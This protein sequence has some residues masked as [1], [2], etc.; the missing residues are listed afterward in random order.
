MPISHRLLVALAVIPT[1][2][3]LALFVY[4]VATIIWTGLTVEAGI[5]LG[6]F[7]DLLS[8]S[9]I[10]RAAW[11]TL[12]QAVVSTAVTLALGL[13]A[14]YLFG[15][16][17]FPGRRLMLSLI[18]IPFVLPTVVVASAFLALTKGW[19]DI[20]A[21]VPTVI[22][23][24]AFFNYAVVV[25]TVSAA[26]SRLDP[27]VEQA[28][29]VLGASPARVM[30]SVT[31]PR[32]RGSITAAAAIVFLFTFTSFGVVLIVGEGRLRTL[33]VETY[34][35]TVQL[36]NLPL[37]AALA[38]VQLAFITVTLLAYSRLRSSQS[39]LRAA[40]R[41][42]ISRDTFSFAA[43]NLLVIVLLLVLPLAA[44]VERSL[45]IGDR[46]GLD[47]YRSLTDA[48]PIGSP[49]EAIQ[50]S[51]GFSVIALAIAV[52]IGALAAAVVAYGRGL[53]AARLFDSLLMLPLG[54]SAV[55]IGF[56][57]LVALDQPIDLRTWWLL[58][59]LSHSLVALPLVVRTVAPVMA[60]IPNR[61]RE[62]AATLGASPARVWTRIDLPIVWRSWLVAAGFAFA[63]SL[64]E[65]G[66]TSFIARP[67]TTTMP[68]MI[69][70]FLSRPGEAN[71]GSAMAMSVILMVVTGTAILA[72]DRFRIAK[73]GEF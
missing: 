22:A 19:F 70:R 2:F 12:W 46:Y 66:A 51:L 29:A 27:S 23:A 67:A 10:R 43:C 7:V 6:A 24:H 17:E 69:F 4:P 30:R 60:G 58:V 8:R 52:T 45:R 65:F 18:T 47:H 50:N 37:A 56:G 40:R 64:G 14:A 38:I 5:S 1:A 41:R 63:I 71:F 28:A 32:L 31:L 25:R 9:S 72:I 36:L 39:S 57:F 55:T 68:T 13:P 73:V 34:L 3:L 21:P 42:R 16:Y 44:L 35:Q 49:V 61:L 26:W 20:D 11:F 33:E 15:R 62:A 48:G 54:T 59:P 53:R